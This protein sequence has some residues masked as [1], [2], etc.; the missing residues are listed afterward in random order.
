M[1]AAILLGGLGAGAAIGAAV[2]GL[3]GGARARAAAEPARRDA[4]ARAGAATA[5][6]DELRRQLGVWQARVG[7]LAEGQEK[8]RSETSQLVGALRAPAVRGRWGEIQLRRALEMAGMLEHCDFLEQATA[9][10]PEGRLRPDVVVR[11]PGR[12]SVVVDAK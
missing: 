9:G 12:K 3:L 2:G 7:E 6:A 10:G 4:E 5:T 8:L 1:D 11:L